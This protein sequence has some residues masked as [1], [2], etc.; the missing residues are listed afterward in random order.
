LIVHAE[1]DD[2]FRHTPDVLKQIPKSEILLI[3]DA[4]YAAHYE[5]PMSFH[6]GLRQFLY[7]VYRPIYKKSF[8][9]NTTKIKQ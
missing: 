6:N 1:K 7:N 8:V 5:K 2:R 3:K 9:S 4:S